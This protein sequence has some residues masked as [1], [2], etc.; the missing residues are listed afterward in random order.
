MK[1]RYSALALLGILSFSVSACS[2][3]YWHTSD[4]SGLEIIGTG[5]EAE[6][7]KAYKEQSV[8]EYY[9]MQDYKDAEHFALRAMRAA[10][11]FTV[12]PGFYEERRIE[13]R[14]VPELEQAHA[15]LIQALE[16]KKVERNYPLLA[17]AQVKYDCWLEQI[18]ENIQPEHIAACRQDFFRALGGLDQPYPDQKLFQVF[19]HTASA[20]LTPIA[21]NMIREAA[22]Y[23]AVYDMHYIITTG[24]TD[25]QGTDANNDAL[26]RKR[27]HAVREFL[28]KEA[29]RPE[30]IR[31]ESKGEH[32]LMVPTPDDTSELKNRRV[33]ILISKP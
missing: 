4:V 33:D 30:F 13:E 16:T 10:D 17:K 32:N 14:F 12:E 9:Q 2:T 25:T 3:G 19:F 28:V 21:K 11:G 6:L 22:R 20:E 24:N 29:I 1:M 15:L 26:S 23:A 7:A 8:F 18:E 31:L 5:F 27:A